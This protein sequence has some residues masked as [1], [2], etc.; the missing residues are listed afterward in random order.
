MEEELEKLKPAGLPADK[1]SWNIEDLQNYIARME[2]EIFHAKALIA[3]KSEIS[4]AADA[5]FTKGNE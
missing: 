2:A 1:Q 3:D 4:A 5:L